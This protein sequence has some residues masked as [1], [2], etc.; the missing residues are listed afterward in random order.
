M[1]QQPVAIVGMACIFPGAPDLVTFWENILE[2]RDAIGP[3]PDDRRPDSHLW[4]GEEESD[5]IVCTRG[6]FI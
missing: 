6:G 4:P 5:R 3:I 1:D 2:G